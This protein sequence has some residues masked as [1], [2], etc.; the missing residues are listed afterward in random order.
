MTTNNISA[1]LPQIRDFQIRFTSGQIINEPVENIREL[2]NIIRIYGRGIIAKISFYF[3][4]SVRGFHNIILRN[5]E[6]NDRFVIEFYHYYN[7]QM[8]RTELS[9]QEQVNDFT[10]VMNC[11]NSR[12]GLQTR[13]IPYIINPF[14]HI[15]M[16]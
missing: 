11:L 12:R 1:Q 5:T 16:T 14:Q 10:A 13:L 9:H 2:S 4:D 3:H 7:S 8:E 15:Q 6:T